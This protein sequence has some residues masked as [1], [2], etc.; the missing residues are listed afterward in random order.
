MKKLLLGAFPPGQKLDVVKNQHIDPS[1][2]LFE[3]AHFVASQRTN[4]FVHEDLG[5]HEQHPAWPCAARV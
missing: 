3:L 1:E 5:R 2:L 4:E